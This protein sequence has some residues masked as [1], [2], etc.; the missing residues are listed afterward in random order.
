M[1][2]LQEL[3]PNFVSDFITQLGTH[4]HLSFKDSILTAGLYFLIMLFAHLGARG[5]ISGVIESI[6][7]PKVK[8]KNMDKIKKSFSRSEKIFLTGLL[9]SVKTRYPFA[10]MTWVI[11]FFNLISLLIAAAALVAYIVTRGAGWIGVVW[12]ISGVAIPL[13][14]IVISL[15]LEFVSVPEV[16]KYRRDRYRW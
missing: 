2:L 15:I 4:H 3:F 7:Y 10:W 11:Y 12:Q 16:R 8:A 9:R 14:S 6:G 13:L 5:I 1:D